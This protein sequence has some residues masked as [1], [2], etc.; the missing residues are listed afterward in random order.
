[1]LP[2]FAPGRSNNEGLVEGEMTENSSWAFQA[3]C[4]MAKKKGV[5]WYIVEGSIAKIYDCISF[6]IM[7]SLFPIGEQAGNYP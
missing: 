7:S 6:M 2:R 1:M 5:Q 3:G 4:L